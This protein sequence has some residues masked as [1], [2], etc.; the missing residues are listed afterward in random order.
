[1]LTDTR[2]HGLMLQLGGIS[3][4][5]RDKDDSVHYGAKV[6]K[7]THTQRLTVTTFVHCYLLTSLLTSLHFCTVSIYRDDA[8]KKE[9]VF[10]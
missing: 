7:C 5:Q 10:S 9:R 6:C 3:H 4:F 8:Q 1:M 2:K